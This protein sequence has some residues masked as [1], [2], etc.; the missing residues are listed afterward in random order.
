MDDPRFSRINW[1]RLLKRLIACAAK[2]FLEEGVSGRDDMLP[3]TG[4]SPKDLAFD[5]TTKFIEGRITFRARSAE[6][7]EKDLFNLLR[8]VMRHDFLD[9]IKPNRAYDKTNVIDAIRSDE[10]EQTGIVLE[11]IQDSSGSDGFYSL[12][13]AA[14][15][16][17]VLPLVSDDPELKEFVEA[18]LCL[19]CWK[20]EDIAAALD[21]TP[22]EVTLRK[23]RLRT[24][25]ASWYR[26]VQAS[27]KWA[28]TH[29]EKEHRPSI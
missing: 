20:R 22:Q 19:G 16:R 24:R 1:D 18:V 21:I 2:W 8:M 27:R 26:S 25:L 6:T 10:G 14:I 29:E 28:S 9:L 15:A 13:A 12:E 5:A 23:E 7:Y 4:K 11:E 3:A 17:K